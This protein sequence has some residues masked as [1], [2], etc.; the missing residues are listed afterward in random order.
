MK[1][2]HIIGLFVGIPVLFF[3]FAGSYFLARKSTE[4]TNDELYSA[5]QLNV[6]KSVDSIQENF[7]K[8]NTEMV[9]EIYKK[10]IKQKEEI[11]KPPAEYVGNN[12]SQLIDNIKSYLEAPSSEDIKSGLVSMELISFSPE[13]I[14]IRKNY[15]DELD[16][17][18]CL[19]IENGYVTVYYSDRKTVFSYTDIAAENL[20]ESVRR[21]LYSGMKI[22]SQGSLYDFLETYSS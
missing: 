10:N 17:E 11:S 21:E 8:S 18:Y 22:E 13:R 4:K 1:K 12:R 7:V 19:Y 5:E 15:A 2:K 20:P 3:I 9:L 16:Y 6:D 14:V